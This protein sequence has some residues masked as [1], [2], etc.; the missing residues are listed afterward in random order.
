MKNTFKI[1]GVFLLINSFFSCGTPEPNLVG[2]YEYID[3]TDGIL[4]EA[5]IK[6]S[7]EGPSGLRWLGPE[8]GQVP[9]TEF[10]DLTFRISP[11]EMGNF[12]NTIEGKLQGKELHVTQKVFE[13]LDLDLETPILKCNRIYIRK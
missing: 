1:I 4:Y 6:S 3:E 13:L 8:V 2:E 9:I 7:S 5:Q 12:I 10:S 11:F